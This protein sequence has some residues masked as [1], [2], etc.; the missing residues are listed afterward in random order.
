MSYKRFLLFGFDTYYPVGGLYDVVGSFET[1]E[2][3][4]AAI[5]ATDPLD[6]LDHYQ[7]FDT[8]TC[9]EID[10]WN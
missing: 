5:A 8:M 2:E 9:K 3:A 6:L 7:I 10:C 1:V 4:A